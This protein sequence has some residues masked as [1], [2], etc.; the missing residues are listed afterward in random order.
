MEYEDSK[1]LFLV[2][3]PLYRALRCRDPQ[4]AER[5][6]DAARLFSSWMEPQSDQSGIS[7]GLWL[8]EKDIYPA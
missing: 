1:N 6:M 5:M 3:Y 7:V 2:H 8:A 4:E